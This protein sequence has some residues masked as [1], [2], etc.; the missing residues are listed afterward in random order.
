MSEPKTAEHQTDNTITIGIQETGYN[1]NGDLFAVVSASF[2][3]NLTKENICIARQ[4][5][6]LCLHP[7]TI[8][9]QWK[10]L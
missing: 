5:Q 1:Q 10:K 8:A 6:Y 4:S 2:P 9:C 3:T 7:T